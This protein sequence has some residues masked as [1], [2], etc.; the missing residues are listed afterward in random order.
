[1]HDDLILK[2]LFSFSNKRKS[3]T[4]IHFKLWHG[5]EGNRPH[6]V[7]TRERNRISNPVIKGKLG[8]C[9]T[10]SFLQY[11]VLSKWLL[12]SEFDIF[13]ST[14]FLRLGQ[15]KEFTI[16]FTHFLKQKKQTWI[17][18][19]TFKTLI[20]NSQKMIFNVLVEML[21]LLAS[22]SFAY[23]SQG[24]KGINLGG[25]GIKGF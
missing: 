11:H 16:S 15:A 24:T 10:F 19:H 2:E 20:F 17:H 1:M 4:S 14:L 22:Y 25:G 8:L 18:K 21:F 6:W 5:S 7:R 3:A 23:S 13:L 12:P 9:L